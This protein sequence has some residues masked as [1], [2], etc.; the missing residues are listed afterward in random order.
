MRTVILVLITVA[1][2][3]CLTLNAQQAFYVSPSGKPSGD[4]TMARPWDLATA[5]SHP[6]QVKPG[7]LIWLRG[8]KYSGTFVSTLKGTATSPIVVRQYANERATL[9]GGFND[10]VVLA[11]AGSYT[12]FWGF[13]IM[14]S[15]GARTADATTELKRAAAIA[16]VQ[17]PGMGV[18]CKFINMSIHD[19]LLGFGWWKDARDS[20]IYGNIIFNNGWDMPDRG[21]G[22]AIYAQNETGTMRISENVILNQFGHGIHL[23][24]S[25]TA[26]LNNFHVSGNITFNN[27]SASSHGFTRNLLVGGGKV[28]QGP[29]VTD[30]HSYYPERCCGT[31]DIGYDAG[32]TNL[33]LSR[34]YF[35][36]KGD[37]ALKLTACAVS[38]IAGNTFYGTTIG[39]NPDVAPANR[40]HLKRPT[41]NETFVRP[42][43][44][45][46]GRAHI[47]VYNWTLQNAVTVNIS[48]AGIPVGRTY[49]LRSAEDYHGQVITGVYNGS[50]I[51]IPMTGWRVSAPQGAPTPRSTLPEFG[52]F[53]ITMN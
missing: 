47:V 20:E 37:T 28:A 5:L 23:Y 22:H 52:A 49:R 29:I 40:Y 46:P 7:S 1:G 12:W 24:G 19:T 30:N 3:L 2:L 32:C 6:P 39:F 31:N 53:I 4:G 25:A 45:E 13:E 14:A 51:S 34:N 50:P 33:N 26:P 48:T 18:G 38:A 43:A 27:G 9:D 8:G 16:N 11:I 10:G 42:N 21:H 15:G 35:I 36:N 41:A 17:S 44:Y